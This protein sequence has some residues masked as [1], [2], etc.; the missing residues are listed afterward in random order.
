MQAND[1]DRARDAL[2][3]IPPDLPRPEWVKAGMGAH[4][5]GLSFDDFDTWSAAGANYK[6]PEARATWRSFKA[7]KG[8]GAASLFGMALSH[9]W[10]DGDSTAPSPKQA[11]RKTVEPPRKPAP[12]NGPAEVW[13]R[14][15]EATNEHSYIKAKRAA[16][17]P[18]DTLCVLPA[19]DPLPPI[20]GESMVVL[21]WCP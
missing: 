18:L 11:T 15:V 14:A 5:A 12:S 19:N 3:S 16:G 21:W 7:G 20:C 8:V 9:G 1:L 2:Y 10:R 6:A 13:G 4:A 17:V